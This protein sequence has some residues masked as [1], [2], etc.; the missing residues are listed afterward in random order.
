MNT[1]MQIPSQ[2]ISLDI[3]LDENVKLADVKRAI[4]MIKGIVK[5]KT[6]TVTKKETGLERAFE[7][8]EAGRVSGPFNSAEELFTHLGI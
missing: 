8:L 1:T 4:N 7:D 3:T 2:T 5:V 6:K